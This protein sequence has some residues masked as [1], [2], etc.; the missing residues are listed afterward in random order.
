MAYVLYKH[1][2]QLFICNVI[3][4]EREKKVMRDILESYPHDMKIKTFSKDCF[5][6]ATETEESVKMKE[7]YIKNF[8]IFHMNLQRIVLKIKSKQY[9]K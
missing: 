5:D 6:G 1:I 3:N 7:K 4:Q 9:R 2:E 8:M